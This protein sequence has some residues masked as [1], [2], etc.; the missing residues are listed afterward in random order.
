MKEIARLAV[1]EL[2]HRHQ[3]KTDLIGFSTGLADVDRAT[4]GL[5]GGSLVVI[6]G[7]PAMGKTCFALN[8][9]D[10]KLADGGIGIMFR[11]LDAHL[12]NISNSFISCCC[13]CKG[14]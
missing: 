14:Q 9:V 13:C 4:G 8:I 12:N 11:H 2:E 10:R 3:A 5:T 6:G 1:N 7:R